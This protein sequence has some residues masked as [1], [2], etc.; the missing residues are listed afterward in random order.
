MHPTHV[1]VRP[2]NDVVV[3]VQC[4]VSGSGDLGIDRRCTAIAL[5]PKATHAEA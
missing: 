3:S 2:G 5:M 1:D 4:N